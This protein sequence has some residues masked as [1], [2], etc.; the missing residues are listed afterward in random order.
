M[1][2]WP[3]SFG[4]LRRS[5]E[6]GASTSTFRTAHPELQDDQIPLRSRHWYLEQ[7]VNLSP[8]DVQVMDH[9]ALFHSIYMCA[10]QNGH[11]QTIIRIL[12][13]H[14]SNDA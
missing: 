9:G 7:H 10:L 5:R 1:T 2:E 6:A 14:C 4:N 8:C 13:E 11:I 12:R 3:W